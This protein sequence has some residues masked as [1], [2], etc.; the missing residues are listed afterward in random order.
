LEGGFSFRK[1][2]EAKTTNPIRCIPL[3]GHLEG[4]EIVFCSINNTGGRRLYK[5]QWTFYLS[6]KP[7]SLGANI[8]SL[9][10]KINDLHMEIK[11]R[12]EENKHRET[13]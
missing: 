5:N 1:L 8:A 2:K 10:N 4:V 3:L 11:R 6:Q 13:Y 9:E 7:A 12:T